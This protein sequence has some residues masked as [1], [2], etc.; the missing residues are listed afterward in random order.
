[1]TVLPHAEFQ[2]LDGLPSDTPANFVTPLWVERTVVLNSTQDP[3]GYSPDP[4]LL[5]SGI[6]ASATDLAPSD[7]EVLSAGI[8]AL[9]GQW[10]S[11]LT[12]EVTHLFA[13]SK[14]SPK[15]ETAIKFQKTINI[16]VLV[17][18]WFDDSVRLGIRGLLTESYG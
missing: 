17:P 12:K 13:L 16:K 10:R 14:G 9:G 11:G 18:H 5:F 6:I 4:A 8:T 2:S 15:Y 1:M 7:L 3:A